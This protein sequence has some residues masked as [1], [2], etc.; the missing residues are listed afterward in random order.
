MGTASFDGLFCRRLRA[1]PRPRVAGA[2]ADVHTV[3]AHLPVRYNERFRPRTT[4]PR[5]TNVA[6]STGLLLAK[7][8]NAQVHVVAY[9]GRGLVRIGTAGAM[10]NTVPVFFETLAP[11]RPGHA[12]GPL[13]LPARRDRD[14]RRHRHDRISCPR[15]S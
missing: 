11:R 9:G 8:L 13:P 15:P 3:I 6:R 4:A 14:H 5:S 12:L 7:W 10:F 2:Q 1:A